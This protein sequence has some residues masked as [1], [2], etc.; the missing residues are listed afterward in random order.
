MIETA[1]AQLRFAA[2]VLFGI[3]FSPRSLDRII[4]GM[5]ASRREFG[6]LG[7]DARELTT[8]PVLDE[9][10][11]R[12]M[13]LRR[14][15]KQATCAAG[16]APYYEELFERIKLDPAKLTWEEL[17]TIPLT[18]KE[19][20]RDH[21]DD[22]I[23]R[24]ARPV[25]RTTTTGTTG[26]PTSVCFSAYEMST[27]IALGAIGLLNE[28]RVT[29]EDIAIIS[30]SSR[31]T[32]GN[33]C[34]AGALARIG[35]LVFNGGLVDPGLTLALLSERHRIPGK[36]E[37]VSVMSTYPSYLGELV[38]E[39]QR[40]GYSPADFGLRRINVGGEIVTEGLKARAHKLFGDHVEYE[41]GYGM[42]EP[43]PLNGTLCEQD[44]LHFEPSQGLIEVYNHDAHR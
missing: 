16:R 15:R 35:V 3:R 1:F 11:R 18:P 17:Q 4:D 9:E 34:A 29:E 32:L 39:G 28:V 24:D 26:R 8:G 22:F 12:D 2:S 38:E 20:I 40:L 42:T 19:D 37:R 44:H 5:L 7:E 30:T 25:F 41:S 43:W 36:R 21:P 13:Q 14:F 10:S 33:L 27:Y 31:A 23:C 6:T